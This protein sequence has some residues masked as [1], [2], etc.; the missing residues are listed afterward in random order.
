MN[1]ID[2]MIERLSECRTVKPPKVILNL[3]EY[4]TLRQA[5]EQKT[6]IPQGKDL[7]KLDRCT[8]GGKKRK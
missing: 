4:T 6:S 7:C 5:S 2:D 1:L 3:E 8:Q